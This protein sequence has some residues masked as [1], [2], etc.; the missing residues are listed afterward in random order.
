MQIRVNMS[1]RASQLFSVV[2]ELSQRAMQEIRRI[3]ATGVLDTV[4]KGTEAKV[5]PC[6]AADLRSQLVVM[7]NL[8]HYFPGLTITGEEQLHTDPSVIVPDLDLDLIPSTLL[9]EGLRELPLA[10]LNVWVDPLD[11]TL[12]FVNRRLEAVTTLIGVTL[13]GRPIFGAVGA[14]FHEPSVVYWGGPGIGVYRSTGTTTW[15][16]LEMP[17]QERLILGCTRSHETEAMTEF[18]NS[19]HPESV[20]RVGG[21]GCKAIKLLL[22]EIAAYVY[23]LP[24]SKKWDSCAIEAL[25]S[26]CLDG[27]LTGMTGEHYNYQIEDSHVLRDGILATR[28]CALHEFIVMTYNASPINKS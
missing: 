19:L 24:Q 1:V 10:D 12:E 17:P 20:V 28:S 3:D 7:S 8:L 26:A 15:E 9:P 2:L 11:G 16:S 25:I 23:P 21:S 4:N 22:G 18:I 27:K 14:V 5:D 6:T 13:H